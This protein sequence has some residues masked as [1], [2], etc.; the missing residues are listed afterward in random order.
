MLQYY[1]TTFRRIIYTKG[2]DNWYD[3]RVSD[4]CTGRKIQRYRHVKPRVIPISISSH[5]LIYTAMKGIAVTKH[6]IQYKRCTNVRLSSVLRLIGQS[7]NM[8]YQFHSTVEHYDITRWTTGL[9]RLVD[10][11][12][13]N[14]WMQIC[15][16]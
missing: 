12:I 16:L 5:A 15:D 1:I 13:I 8:C 11:M 9:M 2:H 3:W 7:F 14:R 6:I 4:P 10:R